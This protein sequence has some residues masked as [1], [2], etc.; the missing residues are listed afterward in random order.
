MD[1]GALDA[2]RDEAGAFVKA[3]GGLDAQAWR[4]PTRC[5]PWQVRGR[6]GHVIISLARV[7]E[8]VHA[9]APDRPDATPTSYYRADDRFSTTANAERVQIAN[10]RGTGHDAATLV[11]DVADVV[12]AVASSCLKEPTDRVVRTPH[13]DAMLL[14]DFLTTRVVELAVHGLDVADAVSREPWL[15]TSAA[16][17]LHELLFGQDWPTAFAALKWDPV[18]LLRKTSGRADVTAKESAELTSLGLRA[19]TLG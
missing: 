7:P 18:T 10:D 5:I 6:V 11:R 14:T 16:E 19:L 8:M 13:G 1:S 9:P 17:H 3:L 15:T 12:Q 2:F 4:R